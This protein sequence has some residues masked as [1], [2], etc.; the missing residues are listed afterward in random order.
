MRPHVC[1]WWLAYTFDHPLRRL[2]QNPYRLLGPYLHEGDTVI[3]AGCG[4]G[5][6]SIPMAQMVG[7]TG[8]VIAV[9]LQ[10]QMFPVLMRRAAREGVAGRVQPHACWADDLGLEVSAQFA[11][12][13]MVV[14]EV[15]DQAR[16]L[17]Q[18]AECLTPTGRFL[19]AEPALHVSR[20]A[21]AMTCT[22]A[23]EAG[24][25]HIESPRVPF[26]HAALFARAG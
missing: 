20:K 15:P 11:L 10:P 17:R 18:V 1:P 23:G 16:F 19:V 14:H 7:E 5:F 8:T 21:F 12:A 13:S 26:C 24:L 25:R 9:D 2:F 3:D 4:M 22:Y 6:F